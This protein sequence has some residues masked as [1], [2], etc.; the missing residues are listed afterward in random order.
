[1]KSVAHLVR[2]DAEALYSFC[3]GRALAQAQVLGHRFGDGVIETP[4]ENMKLERGDRRLHLMGQL[5]HGLADIPVVMD[6]LGDGEP[7]LQ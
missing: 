1:M 4:V 6:D 3:G 5:G 7:H 2:E